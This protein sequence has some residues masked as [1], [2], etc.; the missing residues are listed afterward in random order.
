MNVLRSGT[1][2]DKLIFVSL[3]VTFSG[4]LLGAAL[5]EPGSY[6]FTAILVILIL[7][8]GTYTT[9]SSRLTWLLIF[10]ATAGILE[11]WADWIHVASLGSLVYTDYFGFKLLESPSYMP[12]DGV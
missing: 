4:I 9:R 3:L 10:G 1:T 2:E 6:G 12:I 7:I 11:L 8:A 5:R